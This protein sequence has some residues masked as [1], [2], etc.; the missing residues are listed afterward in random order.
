MTISIR[1][2]IICYI[3]YR[4]LMKNTPSSRCYFYSHHIWRIRR[5]K[6]RKDNWEE[7]EATAFPTMVVG[8]EQHGSVR[9][10][11]APRWRSVE[12]LFVSPRT[13][14]YRYM[15][16]I[17]KLF[18]FSDDTWMWTFGEKYGMN[19]QS[20]FFSFEVFLLVSILF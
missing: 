6:K 16:M 20:C 9:V 5:M 17:I 1:C 3:L 12:D 15:R 18:F 13:L 11:H 14:K 19:N 7:A 8:G 2:Y 4:K 10:A